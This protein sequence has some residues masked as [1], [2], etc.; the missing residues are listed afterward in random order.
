MKESPE[1]KKV[2]IDTNILLDNPEI[3]ISPEIH[4]IIPYTVLSEL[5]NLKRNP[6]LKRPAQLAIK[7]IY[8]GM[9]TGHIEIPGVPTSTTTNDEKIVKAAKKLQVP[10]LT[11]DIGARA[12]AMSRNVKIMEDFEDDS[13]DYDYSGI[14]TIKGDLNYEQD[15]VQIKEL[16]IEEFNLKFN[17]NLKLNQYCI[18]DRVIDKDDIWIRKEEKVL[19]ISQSMK[20]YRDAGITD[21]PLDSEQMCV[22]NAITDPEIP[23]VI[24]SGKLGT[25]KTLLTLMGALACTRG[26]KRFKYY[27]KILVTRPPISIN[28][29]LQLGFLP[30]DLS[31]KLGD[32]IGGIKSNLKFLLE[33]TELQKKEKVSEEV[34]QEYFEMINLDSMQGVSLHDSILIVDEFQLLDVESLKL[35]LS[36]ISEG[37]KVVLVGDYEDQTYGVNRGNE[38]WKVLLKH[39]GTSNEMAFIKLKNMYRSKLAR[40]VDKIFN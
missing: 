27:D 21:S 5:D 34:F 1:A 37:S 19:R 15:F 33:K 11:D 16:P 30:G 39:L 29:K 8:Q 31:E 12:V 26:Q 13:I 25:G 14:I 28:R 20:P 35:V 24:V 6:D 10:I 2:V 9:K 40:F 4:P 23:L 36:R 18:I 32:W 7:L 22:L 38:G 17:T 3:L